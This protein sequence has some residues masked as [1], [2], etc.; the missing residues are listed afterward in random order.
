[1]VLQDEIK[2]KLS[3]L[4]ID[5]L[6]F[7]SLDQ[8]LK[9]IDK[10]EAWLSKGFAAEMNYLST[11]LQKKKH[12]KLLLEGA[13]S[14]LLFTKYYV[15]FPRPKKPTL[16]SL[17]IAKYAQGEDY[18]HWFLE[19]L[20]KITAI[21]SQA[22]PQATFLPMT[23]SK[24]VLERDLATRSGLGWIGKNTCLIDRKKGSYSFIGEIYTTLFIEPTPTDVKSFCG[25]CTACIDSCPTKAI[26]D[27]MLLDSNLC[28]SYL[29]IEAKGVANTQLRPLIGSHFFGCDI[30][31]DVCPWNQKHHKDLL[32]SCQE[33][34]PRSKTI[35]ELKEVLSTSNNGLMRLVRGTPLE[36]AGAIGLKRNALI[37]IANQKLTELEPTVKIYVNHERLGELALWTLDQL[38]H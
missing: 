25:K 27:P 18:H 35:Q 15:P 17:K 24:P 33:L 26:K 5:Q 7:V 22:Y 29:T 11:H 23:D 34:A 12:P 38:S 16:S 28:I 19:S 8:P 32:N 3:D 9:T 31:Q 30:C 13:R 6:G 1:M 21:L 10:Y 20:K 37:V 2:K 36:R 14:A 4:N